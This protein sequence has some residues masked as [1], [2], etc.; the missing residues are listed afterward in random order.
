MY[1]DAI[2]GNAAQMH[3]M[4][5]GGGGGESPHTLGPVWA[6]LMMWV[7]LSVIWISIP[8]PRFHG[9]TIHTLSWFLANWKRELNEFSTRIHTL[10]NLSFLVRNSLTM[11]GSSYNRL[12]ETGNQGGSIWLCPALLATSTKR[13]LQ[14]TTFSHG[15]WFTNWFGRSDLTMGINN[16]TSK[17]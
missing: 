7:R 14:V 15:Y 1:L 13:S 2:C 17:R 10:S 3:E 8:L 12:K 16:L 6:N 9:F 5:G 4:W 11:W